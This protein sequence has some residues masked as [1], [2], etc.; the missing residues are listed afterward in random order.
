[1]DEEERSKQKETTN[2][3]REQRAAY[4]LIQPVGGGGGIKY[5]RGSFQSKVPK[6]PAPHEFAYGSTLVARYV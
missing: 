4:M 6:V 5:V 1:M 3:S 2:L